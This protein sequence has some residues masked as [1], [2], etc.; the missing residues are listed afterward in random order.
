MKCRTPVLLSVSVLNL[1]VTRTF[2]MF[3]ELDIVMSACSATLSLTVQFLFINRMI[4]IQAND[5]IHSHK[6]TRYHT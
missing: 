2:S 6:F 3:Q 5:G 4:S 1:P